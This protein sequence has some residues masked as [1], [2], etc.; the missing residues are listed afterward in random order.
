MIITVKIAE[1][2]E[3]V[4]SVDNFWDFSWGYPPKKIN[5]LKKWLKMDILFFLY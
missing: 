2:E 4:K 5:G 3:V 1:T